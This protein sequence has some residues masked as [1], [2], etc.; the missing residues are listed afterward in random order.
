[1]EQYTH[2]ILLNTNT[3]ELV[4]VSK[5]VMFLCDIKEELNAW[6]EFPGCKKKLDTLN[7]NTNILADKTPYKIQDP[8]SLYLKNNKFFLTINVRDTV[9]LLYELSFAN[10]FDFIQSGKEIGY[11]NNL[12]VKYISVMI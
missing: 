10:I 5:P 7:V 3:W 11:Y 1:M 6:F 12:S 8:I 4:Y 2:I 9:S